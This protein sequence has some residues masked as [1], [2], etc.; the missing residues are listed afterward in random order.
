M[1]R[2]ICPYSAWPSTQSSL[3]G[4]YDSDLER[5]LHCN[6]NLDDDGS[7]TSLF[8]LR[9]LSVITPWLLLGPAASVSRVLG[10][11]SNDEAERQTIFRHS[12]FIVTPHVEQTTPDTHTHT[13]T[14]ARSVN[15]N[16][17]ASAHKLHTHSTV[18]AD[19]YWKTTTPGAEAVANWILFFGVFSLPEY[20][21]HVFPTSSQ[22]LK[23]RCTSP[24][25][26]TCTYFLHPS[27]F[28]EFSVFNQ[29]E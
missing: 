13:H 4:K 5:R 26:P 20:P 24:Y 25:W 7:S 8:H 6:S 21:S 9:M 3:V 18:P 12:F 10:G 14:L 27:R 28:L 19:H 29:V 1:F 22:K 16:N 17:S 23:Q 2:M 11:T 15:N